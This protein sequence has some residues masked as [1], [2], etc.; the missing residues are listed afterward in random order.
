LKIQYIL[1]NTNIVNIFIM[2]LRR[3]KCTYTILNTL[4]ISYNIQVKL[5][6]KTRLIYIANVIKQTKI[7]TCG[8]NETCNRDI[9]YIAY[10]YI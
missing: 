4:Y 2:L 1:N 6:M 7:N 3:Y 10:I 5:V 9:N 8:Y